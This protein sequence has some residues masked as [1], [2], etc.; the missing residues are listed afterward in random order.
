MISASLISTLVL[1]ALVLMTLTEID[2]GPRKQVIKALQSRGAISPATGVSLS[3]LNVTAN[4]TWKRLV[5]DGRVREGPPGQFYLYQPPR[6][7]KRER[8]LKLVF[9]YTV[10]ILIPILL[11]LLN[12]KRH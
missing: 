8:L 10:I 3:E 5:I 6:A 4:G 12:G 2:F 1:L 7:S 11:I 9:F